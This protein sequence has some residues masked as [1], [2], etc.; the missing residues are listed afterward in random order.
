MSAP[1]NPNDE[2]LERV[3]S[4]LNQLSNSQ[5]HLLHAQVLMNDRL[6]KTETFVE[7]LAEQSLRTSEDLQKLTGS[8]GILTEQVRVLADGQKH[9]DARIDALADMVRHLIEGNG[10]GL[11]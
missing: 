6:S 5:R 1:H 11:H 9:S 10:K 7:R 2:L 8:L 3:E 4:V